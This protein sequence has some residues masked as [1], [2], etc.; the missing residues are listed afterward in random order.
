MSEFEQLVK[1]FEAEGVPFQTLE[2]YGEQL[3]G[4][5]L[6]TDTGRIE[7]DKEGKLTLVSLQD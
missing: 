7:F 6:Y 5:T 4:Y 2:I 3:V 1:M